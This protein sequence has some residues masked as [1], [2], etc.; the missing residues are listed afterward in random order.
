MCSV[1]RITINISDD[2]PAVFVR[3]TDSANTRELEWSGEPNKRY[4]RRILRA[5]DTVDP[6]H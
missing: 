4:A 6:A 5:A 1:G 2:G 3:E